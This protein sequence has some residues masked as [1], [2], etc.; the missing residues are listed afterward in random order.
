MT[1]TDLA[2][3]L[4]RS[5]GTLAAA[6]A[7]LAILVTVAASCPTELDDGTTSPTGTTTSQETRP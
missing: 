1:L 6:L 2:R 3:D 4:A 7:L 5:I